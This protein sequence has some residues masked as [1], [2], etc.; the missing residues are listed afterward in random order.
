MARVISIISGKGGVGKTTVSINLATS[1]MELGERVLLV[2][3]DLETPCVS[4]HLGTPSVPITLTSAIKGQH[5]ID[6]TVYV[7][8][9]GLRVVPASLAMHNF[10]K[11]NMTKL[12]KA[13]DALKE[14]ADIIVID[15]P[16]GIGNIV[17]MIL[18][19]S[20]QTIIVTNPELPALADAIKAAKLAEHC[21]TTVLGV[22]VNKVD[23]EP[24]FEVPAHDVEALIEYPIIAALPSE[25]HVKRAL[26]NYIPAVKHAPRSKFSYK[27]NMLAGK[28]VGK[29][30]QIEAPRMRFIDRVF[31]WLGK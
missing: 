14:K 4:V 17:R 11:A 8:S 23:Y 26:S 22:V 10:T 21:E 16:P 30:N 31:G 3:A 28:L 20:D 13:I 6:D 19:K 9:T 25:K 2:D 24:E 15:S 12:G 27:M 7:H 5:H 1:L 18:G 29:S